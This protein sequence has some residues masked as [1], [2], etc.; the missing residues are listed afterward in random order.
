MKSKTLLLCT[1]PIFAVPGGGAR[2][3]AVAVAEPVEYVKVCDAFGASYFYIPGSN[4]CL[5]IG[6]NVEFDA[7]FD[8]I[9]QE[10]SGRVAPSAGRESAIEDDINWWFRTRAE[11]QL[12]GE[13]MTDLGMLNSFVNLRAERGA[14]LSDP[15]SMYAETA[16]AKIGAFK[17]GWD[18]STFDA[19]FVGAIDT[20]TSFDH[21]QHQNQV[22]WST[23][24][25][26]RDFFLAIEDPN[27]SASD[28]QGSEAF[29]PAPNDADNQPG[30]PGARDNEWKGAWPDIV[31]AVSGD[32]GSFSWKGSLGV[33]DTDVGPGLGGQLW[34]QWL[35]GENSVTLQAAMSNGAG[36]LYGANIQPDGY[37]S[38]TYWHVAGQAGFAV[39]PV[40]T[41]LVEAGYA[42]TP[43]PS[44][45]EVTAEGDW[46]VGKGAVFAT[47]L[48]Y[49]SKD[50][51]NDI[52]K[53]S[54]RVNLMFKRS[55]ET[56]E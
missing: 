36:A 2:A 42:Q 25:G 55:F 1:A 28:I 47:E 52:N 24:A 29:A 11:V 18:A 41:V 32:A 12:T 50:L 43:G 40:F 56:E 38:G 54:T 6:G 48:Y 53:S 3:A 23:T 46:M 34:G 7:F 22:Q 20:P 35:Q 4:T 19:D 37:G 9:K 30:I 45:W 15:N 17:V 5:S 33:T 8:S 14:L 13:S 10:R 26:G 31:A 39:T 44:A 16:W 49:L 51:T 21:H 27:D